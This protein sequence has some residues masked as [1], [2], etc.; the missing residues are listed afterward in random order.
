M[1]IPLQNLVQFHGAFA[2]LQAN[3]RQKV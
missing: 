3:L 1:K 2:N